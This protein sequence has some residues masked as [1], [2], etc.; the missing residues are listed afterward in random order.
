MKETRL[1]IR[2]L[3]DQLLTMRHFT[4]IPSTKSYKTKI[5]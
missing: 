4:R 5:S 3:D 2:E 1:F